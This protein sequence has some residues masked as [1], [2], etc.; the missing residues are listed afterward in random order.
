MAFWPRMTEPSA[1]WAPRGVCSS[2]R[3]A[4][5]TRLP[6]GMRATRLNRKIAASREPTNRRAPA[7]K[8]LPASTALLPCCWGQTWKHEKIAGHA[9]GMGHELVARMYMSAAG[10]MVIMLSMRGMWVC[11]SACA[12]AMWQGRQAARGLTNTAVAEVEALGGVVQQLGV[13]VYQ[14]AAD[15][16]LV[17]LA[18]VPPQIMLPL[19]NV[20]PALQSVLAIHCVLLSKVQHAC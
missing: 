9:P 3:M 10:W 7:K 2:A 6:S 8:K 11:R 12:C 14:E 19:H 16:V 15:G 1:S 4:G 20:I 13:E 5:S 18:H 17:G